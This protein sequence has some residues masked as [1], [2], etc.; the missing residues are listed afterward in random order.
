MIRQIA[1]LIV[2]ILVVNYGVQLITTGYFKAAVKLPFNKIDSNS[3]TLVFFRE[4]Y[5][6]SI[7]WPSSVRKTSYFKN[8][9]SLVMFKLSW[10]LK[11]KSLVLVSSFMLIKSLINML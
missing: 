2:E 6:D 7:A 11:K 5:R 9:L 3:E 1:H 4:T 8:Q 10:F